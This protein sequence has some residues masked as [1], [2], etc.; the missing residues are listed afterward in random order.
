MVKVLYGIGYERSFRM[1]TKHQNRRRIVKASL[2]SA[3][4]LSL[5]LGGQVLAAENIVVD[6]GTL[7]GQRIP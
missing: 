5:L 3:V 1:E 6:S 4:L 2:S 7:R